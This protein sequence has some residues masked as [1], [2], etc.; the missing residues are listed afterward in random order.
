MSN[1]WAKRIYLAKETVDFDPGN[2]FDPTNEYGS[3]GHSVHTM[4]CPAYKSYDASV[5]SENFLFSGN[6]NPISR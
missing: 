5:R 4:R 2:K 1:Y 3:N 6:F